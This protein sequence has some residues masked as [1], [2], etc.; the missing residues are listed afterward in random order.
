[1]QPIRLAYQAPVQQGAVVVLPAAV[2]GRMARVG[3]AVLDCFLP[4]SPVSGWRSFFPI[5]VMADRALG[6]M[7]YNVHKFRAERSV[8][9]LE[10]GFADRPEL[11][12][13]ERDI[14]ATGL[15]VKRHAKAVFQNLQRVAPDWP[16]SLWDLNPTGPNRW[17]WELLVE[18]REVRNAFAFPGGKIVVF[19]GLLQDCWNY[20]RARQREV[21]AGGEWAVEVRR[22]GPNGAERRVAVDLSSV[23]YEDMVA[24]LIGHEMTHVVARH[25]LFSLL[26]RAMLNL[27]LILCIELLRRI[28]SRSMEGVHGER[29]TQEDP[30]LV[31]SIVNVLMLWKSRINEYEADAFGMTLAKRA[32]YNPLGAVALQ[33]LF[34]RVQPKTTWLHQAMNLL[35]THPRS[36]FRISALVDKLRKD[37]E[38]RA[39]VRPVVA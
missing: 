32:A 28:A 39:V 3:T 10:L 7:A 2:Q 25:G 26:I 30:S 17:G 16:R 36:D 27:M 13:G 31:D 37:P 20:I 35:E 24:A 23:R 12:T 22:P 18:G 15:R 14:L 33:D 4:R 8:K 19:D 6:F 38:M 9:V 29:I 5:P 34:R 21:R 1:M 11:V